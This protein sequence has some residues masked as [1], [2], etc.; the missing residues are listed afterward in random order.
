M[1]A[2]QRG[3]ALPSPSLWPQSGFSNA[4]AGWNS[5]QTPGEISFIVS[6]VRQSGT[7]RRCSRALLLRNKSSRQYSAWSA[8]AT[9]CAEAA[10]AR[11]TLR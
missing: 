8:W 2:N 7:G 10:V 4:T 6:S 1:A 11:S 3:A 9:R 5:T